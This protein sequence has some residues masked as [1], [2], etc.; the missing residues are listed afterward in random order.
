[1]CGVDQ[2]FVT[3]WT[4]ARQAPLS[5]GFSRKEYWSGSPCPPPGDLP[6]LGIEPRSPTF[7]ENSLLSESP[8]KPKDTGVG[9]LFLLQGNFPTQELNQGLRHCRQLF[10]FFFTS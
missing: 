1:M 10:F 5:M 3:P 2:S 9:G 7:L 8:E 4:A 6:N